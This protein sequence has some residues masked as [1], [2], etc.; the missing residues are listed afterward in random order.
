MS[1]FV[2]SKEGRIYGIAERQ[3]RGYYFRANRM[4]GVTGENLLM[5]PERRLD[6]VGLPSGSFASDHAG[7]APARASRT[8]LV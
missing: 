2:R 8:L 5:L 3:F 6:N 1:S 4:K 7:G